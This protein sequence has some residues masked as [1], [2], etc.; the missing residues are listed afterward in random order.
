MHTGM[1]NSGNQRFVLHSRYYFS[2]LSKENQ[3]LYRAIYDGWA[4]GASKVDLIIPGS[5]FDAYRGLS[6]HNLVEYIIMD[7][8]HLFHLETS[9]FN[10][11]RLG[12]K[13]T[14]SAEPV[15]SPDEYSEIYQKLI[16]C[17]NR[18]RAV[19]AFSGNFL[20]KI[21]YIHDFL[22]SEISYDKGLPS[23]RSQREI[24]TIVGALLN[25][26]CVCDGYA[27]AMRLL[28]DLSQIS[29]IVVT[30]IGKTETGGERHA[31]NIVK[32]NGTK[33]QIDTTWDSNLA[34]NDCVSRLFFLRDDL[35]F[36]R[37]HVWDRNFYPSCSSDYPRKEPVV[38]NQRDLDL[39]I[40]EKLEKRHNRISF[41]GKDL[42][43]SQ[44]EFGAHLKESIN[45]AIAGVSI[46]ISYSYSKHVLQPYYHIYMQY[47]EN[48]L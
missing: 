24:H 41:Y 16:L 27:R 43:W 42:Q 30:G 26:A 19:P 14:I 34:D 29:C 23:A 13:V 36:A 17:T 4:R 44:D 10:Y 45:K 18:I 3:S 12:V 32:N 48:I 7:N 2:R 38:A 33:Y 9:Q 35:M 11:S 6:L 22:A 47:K 39:L 40:R 37:D 5:G 46:E 20:R 1:N 8:P 25:K 31:W 21:S 28:C 15:Y